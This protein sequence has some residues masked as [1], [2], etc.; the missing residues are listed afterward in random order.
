MYHVPFGTWNGHIAVCVG[1][2]VFCWA[3]WE[4]PAAIT[5]L[6]PGI[7]VGSVTVTDGCAIDYVSVVGR[8]RVTRVRQVLEGLSFPV[9]VARVWLPARWCLWLCGWHRLDHRTQLCG[10]WT[11]LQRS[12][13][14]PFWEHPS[15]PWCWWE[16]RTLVRP[17][18]GSVGGISRLEERVTEAWIWQENCSWVPLTRC[19]V[20]TRDSRPWAPLGK[21]EPSA[22]CRKI[23]G[24]G[25]W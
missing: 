25:R 16:P 19:Q 18:L 23:R 20:D 15:L 10:V 6:T 8:K 21:L 12:Y 7:C 13:H 11:S 3:L 17:A 14:G 4:T 24:A 1:G 2:S 22:V 9:S 5:H